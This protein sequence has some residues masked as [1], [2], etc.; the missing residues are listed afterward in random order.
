MNKYINNVGKTGS[1]FANNAA[2]AVLLYVVVGKLTNHI[3]LEEFEDFHV[4]DS[5]KVGVYGGLTGMLYKSTRGYR[6]M[7]LGGMMGAVVG[8]SFNLAFM[9]W[10]SQE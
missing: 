5:I 1:R 9:R 4:N 6:P 2:A 7:L 3:F 8:T 10:R